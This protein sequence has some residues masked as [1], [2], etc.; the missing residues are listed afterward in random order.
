M[1]FGF[2]GKVWLYR[3]PVDFRKQIDGLVYLIA[4]ELKKDPVSG[5]LFVF[6]NRFGSK[7]KLLWWDQNG[8]WLM[9]KRLE[10]GRFRFPF[11]DELGWLLSGIDFTTQKKPCEVTAKNFI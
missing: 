6:R 11:K 8:F 10:R 1:W 9:Y 3:H 4:D 7:I 5:Q 2:S